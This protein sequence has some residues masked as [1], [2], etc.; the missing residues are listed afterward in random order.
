MKARAS[1]ATHL[2]PQAPAMAAQIGFWKKLVTLRTGRRSAATTPPDAEGH[3]PATLA[4]AAE[5]ARV[6]AEIHTALVMTVESLDRIIAR[7]ETQIRLLSARLSER[8]IPTVEDP[9]ESMTATQ[10]DVIRLQQVRAHEAAARMSAAQHELDEIKGQV[11]ELS[12]RREHLHT[13]AAG[14][15]ASWVARFDALTAHHRSGFIRALTRRFPTP[16]LSIQDPKNLPMPSYKPNHAWALGE[17]LPVT[18][19]EIRP[20]DQPTLMWSHLRWDL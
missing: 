3:H 10:Q 16:V 19:T 8:T 9:A 20:N 17:Q 6:E 7:S 1:A 13:T 18:V 15:L 5:V 4:L 11:A 2:L 12:E 14:I